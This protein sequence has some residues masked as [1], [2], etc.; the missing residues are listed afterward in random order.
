[1][2]VTVCQI[3]S[4]EGVLDQY[5]ALLASHIKA[6]GSN[7]VLLPE[8]G[9]SEWLA[10][11]KT[12]DAIRWEKAADN[13]TRYIDNLNRLGVSTVVG[14]RPI[15]KPS[16]SRRNEAYIWTKASNKAIG[17]H[18][19]Y[20]L[21]DEEGYWEHSWYD[22]GP[23]SFDTVRFGDVRIGV[24]IC[25]EMWFFEWARH[26]AAAKVDIL[27][28]PRATPHATNDKWLAGGR[29]SAVCAGAYN[30]SSNL[31]YPKGSKADCGGL[32]WII[33]PD[34][35]VLATTNAETPFAT[36]EIDLTF[37]QTSK[38]TYPRY[39]PE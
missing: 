19:K 24:Q 38:R 39:V 22:R 18:E 8:M 9:F 7:F 30:L 20:Y 33:D 28:V 29:A 10:A 37:A 36:V 15:I 35:T 5:L 3:D 31:W 26:Y 2:K 32:S 34:G 17:F 25:T 16:G 14:T 23:K 27:C 13:H 11:D 12:P 1:M 6:E 21:P 4:R